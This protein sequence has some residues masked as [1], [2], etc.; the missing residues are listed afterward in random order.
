MAD[1]ATGKLLRKQPM[2]R[3]VVIALL[4]CVAGAIYFYGWRALAMVLV[5]A[6]VGFAVE[7]YS[8]KRRKEPVTEAVF[9]TTTIYA[10]IMPP[11]VPWHV[12]IIGLVFAV[13]MAKELFGGFGRNIFNPA[14]AGRC[15]VFICFPIALTA[16]WAQVAD[17]PWGALDRWTTA[18]SPQA[19][20]GATPMALMKAGHIVPVSADT[21]GVVHSVPFH[22]EE[23]T[24]AKV[25]HAALLQALITGRI[26]GTMGVN[27]I[28]LVLIG[29]IYLF[30]TKTASRTIILSTII[31]YA[32]WS[33][34]L[35][36]AGVPWMHGPQYPLLGGG[37]LFGTFFMAT[38]PVSAPKTWQAQLAYGVIIGTFTTI[39]RNFSIFNG[40]LMFSI[41]IANMFAP[42]MDYAVK[43]YQS[44]GAAAEGG[45][46]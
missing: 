2:I 1:S 40:G 39:I 23:G 41:I 17:G 6:A 24:V 12:L 44:R 34:V 22:I 30:W 36:L 29:G 37:F 7:W 43:A 20:T 27:S 14:M 28:I 11:S 25:S 3:R 46:A 18:A 10:L 35:G 33:T 42:I 5:C 8:C 13:G 31:S 15:F 4:P 32:F 38:D 9:V 16:T 21:E 26:S 19:V 45:S